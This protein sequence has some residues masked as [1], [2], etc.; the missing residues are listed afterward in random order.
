ATGAALNSAAQSRAVQVRSSVESHK[1]IY[2]QA[3]VSGPLVYVSTTNSGV[4]NNGTTQTGTNKFIHIVIALAGHQV[5]SIPTIYFNDK[6]V[7]LDGNGFVT[8]APYTTNGH[9]FA[10]VLTHLGS[11][12][13]SA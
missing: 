11:P 8:T 12:T 6:P 13:Q 2:G 7:S 10:R 5:D 9:S 1:I 3:K 4:D